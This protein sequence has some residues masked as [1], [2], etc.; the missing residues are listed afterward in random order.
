MGITKELEKLG[1]VEID[2]NQTIVCVV[3]NMVAEKTGVIHHVFD[4]LAGIPI[5][6][7]SYGGS[8]HNI[9]ILVNSEHKIQAL[10]DLNQ[11][12]FQSKIDLATS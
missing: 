9:S 8:R 6:M 2:K 5:R 1:I 11:G 3:G 7:V 10:R 4:A 12:L